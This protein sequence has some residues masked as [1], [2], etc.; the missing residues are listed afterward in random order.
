[1]RPVERIGLAALGA[2]LLTC[3]W[4]L[5]AWV[6]RNG[7]R[8]AGECINHFGERYDCSWIDW[9]ARGIRSPFAW[10]ALLL[11]FALCWL[12]LGL[13]RRRTERRPR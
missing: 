11:L 12:L 13:A 5:W 9:I 8:S 1:M 2:L 4:Q 7:W 6:E 10:P 3:A